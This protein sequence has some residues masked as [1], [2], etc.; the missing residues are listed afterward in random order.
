MDSH[1]QAYAEGSPALLTPPRSFGTDS[2]NH[3]ETGTPTSAPT[4]THVP[5]ASHAPMPSTASQQA[6]EK[7]KANIRV[8]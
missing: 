5:T 1:A 2:T 7:M 4:P 3:Y 8:H 6:I